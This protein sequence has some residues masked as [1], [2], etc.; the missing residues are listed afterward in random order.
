MLQYL[1]DNYLRGYRL[2]RIR[3]AIGPYRLGVNEKREMWLMGSNSNTPIRRLSTE[4]VAVRGC[5]MGT[6]LLFPDRTE[7]WMWE[8][9]PREKVSTETVQLYLESSE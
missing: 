4:V 8:L 3:T 5:P 7:C 9:L 2:P 1:V 6:Y